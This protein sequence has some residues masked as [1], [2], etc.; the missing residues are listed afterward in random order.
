MVDQRMQE[1]FAMLKESVTQQMTDVETQ[2]NLL[3][4]ETTTMQGLLEETHQ[5]IVDLVKRWRNGTVQ[6]RQELAWSLYPDGLVFS[7]YTFRG[8]KLLPA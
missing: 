5:S 7:R 8:W 4:A 3:D 6:M 2:L 1:D